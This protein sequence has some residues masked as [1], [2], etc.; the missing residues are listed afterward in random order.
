MTGSSKFSFTAGEGVPGH[1][2]SSG[3]SVLSA[4]GHRHKANPAS[5]RGKGFQ[6]QIQSKSHLY[7]LGLEAPRLA[8]FLTRP[9][10]SKAKQT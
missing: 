7:N 9:T 6:T 8:V 5:D 10:E 4:T 1:E 3:D 2:M